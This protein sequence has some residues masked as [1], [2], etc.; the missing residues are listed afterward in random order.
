MNLAA[1]KKVKQYKKK[2]SKCV[3]QS[4]GRGCLCTGGSHVEPAPN[5]H[6]FNNAVVNRNVY[7]GFMFTFG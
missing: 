4:R 5:K 1:D 7:A 6:V 3:I 2:S